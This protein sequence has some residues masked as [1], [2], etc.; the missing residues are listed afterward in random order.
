MRKRSGMAQMPHRL[1]ALLVALVFLSAGVPAGAQQTPPPTVGGYILGSG[2]VLEVSV[3]G[4][5][6]LTRTVAVR[7]DGQITV[8]LVGTVTASG[9]SVEEL[10]RVLTRAY[11][12]FIRNPQVTVIVKEFRSIRISVL[13]QVAK[14]GSYSLPPGSRVL[15]A[16]SAAGGILNSALV[17]EVRVMRSNRQTVTLQTDALLRADARNNPQ[18]LGG[19]TIYVPEVNKLSVSI[20]GQV[21]R[22]GS[23]ELLPGT[24]LLDLLSVAGGVTDVAALR[25]AQLLRP[26]EQPAVVDLEKVLAGDADANVTLRGGETLVVREDLVNVVNVMGEVARPGRYRLKGEMRLVDVLLL[27]GGLTDRASVTQARLVRARESQ[28]L[29][30]DNLLLRQDMNYNIVMQPGDSVF[31]PE[32]TNNRFYVLGDVA[33]PGVFTTKGGLTVLQAIAMAGGPVQRGASTAK[34]AHI[35][36]RTGTPEPAVTASLTGVKVESLPN[37]ASMV[38][39]DLRALVQAGDTRRDVPI[40]PGDVLVVPQTT[41]AGMSGILSILSGVFWFF[42]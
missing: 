42:R 39:L 38:T 32:E 28:T 22:P 23:Y 26:G 1:T 10:T 7:P 35:I 6:D 21:H 34:T 18:L 17:K 12:A 33:R 27:A 40:Q 16:I 13:G 9:V 4:Y 14:P 36:R 37:G 29:N 41:L 11:S 25:E 31:V 19:E 24:R 3:W 20:V 30:L 2:D 5:A 8:P 15:E